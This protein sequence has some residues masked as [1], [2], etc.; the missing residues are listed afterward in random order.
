MQSGYKRGLSIDRID[1]DK[2]YSSDNCRWTDRLTQNTNKRVDRRNTS[3]YTG[4]SWDK[5]RNKWESHITL[6][7][8]K[9]FSKMCATK[10]EALQKRN[11]Y[12]EENG[13]P[14]KKQEYKGELKWSGLNKNYKEFMEK[15]C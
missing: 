1:N 6:N 15:Q 7:R 4:V 13:L 3:G 12:I 9:I 11:N 2:G 10:Q 14:H 8:K 5:V